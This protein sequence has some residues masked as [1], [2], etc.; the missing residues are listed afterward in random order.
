MGLFNRKKRR[1]PEDWV[2]QYTIGYG[3]VVWR[4]SL[5]AAWNEQRDQVVHFPTCPTQQARP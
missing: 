3:Y 5:C 4:C 2:E 1:D